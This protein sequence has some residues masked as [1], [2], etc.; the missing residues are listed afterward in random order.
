M[1]FQDYSSPKHASF[2][3]ARAQQG[4]LSQFASQ[5]KG[6]VSFDSLREALR[7]CKATAFNVDITQDFQGPF[8]EFPQVLTIDIPELPRHPKARNQKLS[9]YDA[10]LEFIT[11]N[12]ASGK[13]WHIFYATTPRVAKVSHAHQSYEYEG[14]SLDQQMVHQDLKRDTSSHLRQ[15]IRP[16]A[17][18]ETDD[19]GLF[20]SY[21]FLNQGVFMGLVA[22]FLLIPILYV[23]FSAL[24]S[25]QISEQAFTKEQAQAGQRKQQ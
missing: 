8:D 7:R 2:F 15:Q 1:S 22:G 18:N 16:Q 20:E 9:D 12:Y 10:Y 5:A 25:L 6:N 23:G 14:S 21:A 24:G 4:E 19:R 11:K 13:R 3:A 17:S